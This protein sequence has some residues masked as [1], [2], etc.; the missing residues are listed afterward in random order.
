MFEVSESTLRFWPS[1]ASAKK[2]RSAIQKSLVEAPLELGRL[3]LELGRPARGRPRP[4]APAARSGAWRRRRSP[5]ARR[6]RAASAPA[7]RRRTRSSPRSPS[8][9]GCR[10][11]SPVAPLVLDVAVAVAVAV[12]VDPAERRARLAL[13]RA[14]ERAVA[15]PALVLLEQDQEQ[16]RRVG[17]SRSTASGGAPRTRS[18]R[19]SAAR[20]GS[21]R[22]PRR[23]TDRPCA[24]GAA[25]SV[26][27]V[28]AASSGTNGSAWKLVIRLSRPKIAMNQ[29]SPAAGSAPGAMPGEAQRR[30]VDQAAP[31][32]LAR[33]APR[34]RSARGAAR[35]TAARPRSSAGVWR[36]VAVRAGAR[37]FDV[38]APT[39][40]PT[41]KHVDQRRLR[42]ELHLE[43]EA[44]PRSSRA[45]SLRRMTVSRTK[46]SRR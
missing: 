31:V 23:G 15:G 42:R 45:G 46:L 18:S 2:P 44:L 26:R 27:S 22:A 34:S 29:G 33:A 28:A 41:S 6:S 3:A 14:H 39:A 35:S 4:R 32:D 19:R 17:A 5:G 38:G 21:C 1:S 9:T 8:S 24:P 13:E 20:A 30:Q 25:A 10:A 7:C 12:A 43:D 36:R 16:R 11:R 37:V 40:R